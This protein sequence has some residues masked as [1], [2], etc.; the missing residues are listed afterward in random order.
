MS[1]FYR[2]LNN[3]KISDNETGRGEGRGEKN[4]NEIAAPF[5]PSLLAMSKKT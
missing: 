4:G 1:R 2:A 5:A 3:E